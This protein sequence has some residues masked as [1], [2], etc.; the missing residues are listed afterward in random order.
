MNINKGHPAVNYET[1]F[2]AGK[3]IDHAES[4]LYFEVV[5]YETYHG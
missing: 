5:T 3:A 2:G 1:I 4:L